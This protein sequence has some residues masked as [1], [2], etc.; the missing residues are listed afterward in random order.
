MW[1]VLCGFR[2]Y[3]SFVLVGGHASRQCIRPLP[4]GHLPQGDLHVE[5][6]LQEWVSYQRLQLQCVDACIF[7]PAER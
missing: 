3:R 1:C 2:C 6:N 5:E 7:S 4:A